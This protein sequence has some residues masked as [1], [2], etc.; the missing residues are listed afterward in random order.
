MRAR[1]LI[2]NVNGVLRMQLLFSFLFRNID[3]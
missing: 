1:M 2:I 3:S